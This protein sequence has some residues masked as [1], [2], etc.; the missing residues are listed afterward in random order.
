MAKKES[1][2]ETPRSGKKEVTEKPKV[3]S[4]PTK[5]TLMDA[6][7]TGKKEEAKGKTGTPKQE[8]QKTEEKKDT[9]A[10]PKKEEV[11]KIEQD[12]A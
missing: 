6:K 5:R 7:K 4:S 9:K 12:E 3:Q 11:K 10:Q 2:K 8:P 1:T